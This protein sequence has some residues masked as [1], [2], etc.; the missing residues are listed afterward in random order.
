MRTEEIVRSS[1]AEIDDITGDEVRALHGQG[2]TSVTELANLTYD[3]ALEYARLTG[4]DEHRMVD[5][6]WPAAKQIAEVK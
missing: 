3:Q 5:E 1:L 4:I 2:V 6:L